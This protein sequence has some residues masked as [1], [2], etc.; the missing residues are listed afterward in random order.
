[1]MTFIKFVAGIIGIVVM[2]AILNFIFVLFMIDNF[3]NMP[4]CE[5]HPNQ[6]MEYKIESSSKNW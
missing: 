6:K 3:K 2:L 5:G 4:C 1:M